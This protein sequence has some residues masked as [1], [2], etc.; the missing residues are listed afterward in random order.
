[1]PFTK[2]VT[3]DFVME[4]HVMDSI[5]KFLRTNSKPKC[6]RP[7]SYDFGVE[8]FIGYSKLEWFITDSKLKFVI[9][10]KSPIVSP[11]MHHSMELF[12]FIGFY[13][14]LIDQKLSSIWCFGILVC[15]YQNCFF[16]WLWFFIYTD[17][18]YKHPK[19]LLVSP[20]CVFAF[21]WW[22]L[23]LWEFIP[24]IGRVFCLLMFTKMGFMSNLWM[25][26]SNTILLGRQCYIF[27]KLNHCFLNFL[28]CSFL[29]FVNQEN[30]SPIEKGLI[31][32]FCWAHNVVFHYFIPIQYASS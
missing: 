30:M 15:C 13:W 8:C 17:F 16:H 28:E 21:R 19:S 24:C 22:L 18:Q 31:L 20:F 3:S 7:T 26:T 4:S 23:I 6:S 27:Y 2:F 11:K 5:P 9:E 14:N 32:W 29:P 1:M 10:P 12:F 25:L